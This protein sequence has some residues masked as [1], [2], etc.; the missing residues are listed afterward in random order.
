MIRRLRKMSWKA[1]LCAALGPAALGAA[2]LLWVVPLFY[3]VPDL[4]AWQ[5][6][7]VV[8]RDRNGLALAHLPSPGHYR[9]SR[10]PC[11]NLP[12]DLVAAT[13]AAEDKRFFSH[14]GVDFAAMLRAAWSQVAPGVR[15]SGASTVSQQLVKLSSPPSP[16]TLP[17]KFCEI[18]TAR[19]LEMT[20][21]KRTILSAYFDR[22]DYG[23]LRTGPAAA[24]E[25]Y[26]GQRLDQLSLAQTALLAG[27]PQSPT[28]LNPR[29]NPEQALKRR[30]WILSRL[31]EEFG[32]DAERIERAK[33][34][35]LDLARH[36][37]KTS[38]APH[39]LS[40][41][42]RDRPAS[43]EVVTTLDA[44]LQ[45]A[46]E[47]AVADV[48]ASLSDKRV[49]QAAVVVLHNPTGEILAWVGSSSRRDPRGGQLDG[50]LVPR[51]AG[52]T[53]KPFVYAMA[54]G[55]GHWAGEILADVPMTYRTASGFD[56]P[57]NYN[58]DYRGPLSAREALACSQNI[59]AMSLLESSGG[60]GEL[61]V[62]LRRLGF[63]TVNRNS[64]HYGLGLAIGNAEV[65]L[66]D[67]VNAYAVLARRGMARQSIWKRGGEEFAPRRVM[68][69]DVCF[70]VTDILSD[71]EARAAA[72]G[73]SSPLAF[74]FA[75][76][77]KTGTS[78]DYRDNWCVG[79]TADVTVGVWVGNF[80]F[81]RMRDVSG[82]SG[83]GPVFHQVM[84]EAHRRYPSSFPPPTS[85][86]TRVKVDRRNGLRCEDGPHAVDEWAWSA[87]LP[88]KADAADYG[89]RGR[90]LLDSRYRAWYESESNRLSALYELR[91]QRWGGEPP[92]IIVP[93]AQ[94]TM[95]I[96]PELP[97]SGRIVRLR[98]NLPDGVRWQCDTLKVVDD[99]GHPAVE[100]EPGLHTIRATHPQEG[101][102]AESTFRV[103]RL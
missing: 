37:D 38:L 47:R 16:R 46:A 51:S 95:A 33:Q 13:L 5:P 62:L 10:T 22:L 98:S 7:G 85:G 27:L 91:P 94:S 35:P 49:T 56:A 58:N 39:V 79:Y 88:R 36:P 59:P 32:Y 93:P 68:D 53:L 84:K 90:A 101:L 66:L 73:L 34:E 52:S 50:A 57:K 82:V 25:Y 23:N 99:H 77:A 86:V 29:R 72:F 30:N 42:M 2:T 8:V 1:R 65:R 45:Q 26:F 15:K 60:P 69:E 20:H 4:D 18:M 55:Q 11:E 97:G 12:D 48:T 24:A 43:G 67:L 40:R 96:D 71:N 41:I 75:C 87:S 14:G 81:S 28:R 83:A 9:G 44:G 102:S 31:Q 17:T 74:D 63:A 6:P 3:A 61:A 70:V 54:F 76:A 103:I 92:R 80:D 89:S 78:S 19:H 64:S 100:L 21:D